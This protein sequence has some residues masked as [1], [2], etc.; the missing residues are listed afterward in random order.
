MRKRS[1][2][3]ARPGQRMPMPA[4]AASLRFAMRQHPAALFENGVDA[5]VERTRSLVN[6]DASSDDL[7]RRKLHFIHDALPLWNFWRG[8]RALELVPKRFCINVICKMLVLPWSAPGRQISGQ[9]ME[10]NLRGGF[11]KIF[12]HSPCGLRAPGRAED[13]QAGAS[14]G[15]GAW[16]VGSRQRCS[17]PV[18]TMLGRQATLEL[19]D[20]PWPGHVEGKITSSELG[21]DVGNGAVVHG[22]RPAI[23]KH[24]RIKIQCA[25]KSRPGKMS[26]LAV[27]A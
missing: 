3:P 24:P 26:P 15:G 20:I 22:R 10:A 27:L 12:D 16:T 2:S 7:L 8:A 6:A 9:R 21:P 1:R 4:A 25:V 23:A 17:Q 19:L 11:G 13:H 14:C 18:A 5:P